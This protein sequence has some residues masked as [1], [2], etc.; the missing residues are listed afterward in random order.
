[1]SDANIGKLIHEAATLRYSRRQILKR[2]GALGLS[3]SA[4]SAVLARTASSAPNPGPSRR[5]AAF[6]QGSKL[7]ILASTYF[8]APGQDHYTQQAQAWGAQNGVEVTV[9][10]VNWPDLQPKIGAAVQGG[11]GPDIVEM[12]DTWPYLYYQ[13]MVE[14]NDLANKV[15]Q[16]GGGYYDWVTK[17]VAV[18]NNWYSVPVGFSSAAIAYRPSYF[19]E[20]GLS[21]PVNGFPQTWEELF[22]IGKNLKAMGKPI[23]QALG[24]SL[25]DPP[26]FAYAYMWSYGAMEREEDGKTIAFNQPQ[27]VEGMKLFIQ[28]WKDAF[29]ETGLSWDDSA[30]NR[31]FL[32]DQISMTIN[33]SS[34][35]ITAQEAAAGTAENAAD[36]VVDPADINHASFPGG[37]AGRFNVLGSRSYGIMKY[38]KNQDAARQYLEWWSA[39][40]RFQPWLEVQKG[41]I[42]PPLPTYTENPIYTEDPKLAP[43]L[44][45]VNYGR[46][47]GYA[48]AADQKAALASSQYI[49]TDTFTRAIQTGDAEAAIM[50]GAEQLKR[51]YSR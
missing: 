6:L 2:A 46:N 4:L 36:V 12:W 29:D 27:F 42:I 31:A 32:S 35:Y 33:G 22:K 14:V 23:G 43:Y 24:H 8:V 25:G 9:D 47:K 13:N 7:N 39:P 18:D 48:G 1:M 44:E 15:G 11:N 20:A 26:N 41:Y 38:S 10:Y 51:V 34:I 3:A 17:T 50:Q 30:N 21:D 28:G 19:A 37:P 45:V 49:V 40:E 16:A 5:A